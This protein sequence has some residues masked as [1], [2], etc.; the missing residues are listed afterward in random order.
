MAVHFGRVVE[1]VALHP[2]RT[3]S[4]LPLLDEEERRGLQDLGAGA[5][6]STAAPPDFVVWFKQQAA[7]HPAA[8]AVIFQ[9]RVTTYHDLDRQSAAVAS[10]LR[11]E[12]VRPEEPV[13]LAIEPGAD[14]SPRSSASPGGLCV[15]STG[16]RIPE[17]AWVS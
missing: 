6:D 5:I 10:C 7:L 15:R 11:A 17:D 1:A 13:G 3:L 14:R 8:A 9:D 16:P 4:D 2:D 12:A